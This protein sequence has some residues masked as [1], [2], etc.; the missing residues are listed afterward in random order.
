MKNLIVLLAFVGFLTTGCASEPKA[1]CGSGGVCCAAEAAG[2]VSEDGWINMFDGQSFDG[3]KVNGENPET[4]KIIDGQIV[5]HGP[6]SH[7][8]YVGSDGAADFTDFEVSLDILTTPGSNSGFY[9]HT[10]YQDEGW[11]KQGY[12]IQV[13]NSHKDPKRSGSVYAVDNVSNPPTQDN[14]W[15]NMNV[16]VEGKHVVV[17]LDGAIVVDY[18]EEENPV[19]DKGWDGRR[20]THGTFAIQGH[21]P[22]SLVYYKNLKVRHLN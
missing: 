15:Y 18:T 9:I 19:R 14:V 3:W 12:E 5:A 6:R 8:F 20:F 1:C 13:N 4:F 7:L 17:K 2:A 21:D 11:P 10:T 22:A 16:R